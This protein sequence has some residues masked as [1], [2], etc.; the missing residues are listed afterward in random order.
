MT[1][2]FSM[3]YDTTLRSFGA[4]FLSPTDQGGK[5]FKTVPP[6]GMG[7]SR[8]LQTQINGKTG[9]VMLSN[10]TARRRSER[11]LVPGCSR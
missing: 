5:L 7:Y 2:L 6:G 3:E 8:E 11:C 9:A 4:L 10:V 1:S